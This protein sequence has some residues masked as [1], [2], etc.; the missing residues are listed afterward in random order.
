MSHQFQEYFQPPPNHSR[1][2]YTKESEQ[3]LKRTLQA[4]N[5]CDT[6]ST[7]ICTELHRQDQ[8]I[9]R[10]NNGCDDIE[11]NL[12]R[13][14]DVVDDIERMT[15]IPGGFGGFWGGGSEALDPGVKRA[16]KRDYIWKLWYNLI[17]QEYNPTSDNINSDISS[18][19]G[20][21]STKKSTESDKNRYLKDNISESDTVSTS[22][23][24]ESSQMRI[25]TFQDSKRK[26][27]SSS[28]YAN[29]TSHNNEAENQA[30]DQLDCILGSLKEKSLTI[31]Q[32]IGQQSKKLEKM[33]EKIDNNRTKMKKLEERTKNIK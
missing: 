5:Q 18:D 15:C 20:P 23:P 3:S 6:T 24:S 25:S 8:V 33:D 9:D 17:G 1:D 28:K 12:E 26:P 4:A 21:N 22:A 32:T 10:I 2:F 13:G 29:I 30:F 14:E 16:R 31:G 19:S 11:D 7:K 27:K